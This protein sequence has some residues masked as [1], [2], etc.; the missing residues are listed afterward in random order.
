MFSILDEASGV[1]SVQPAGCHSSLHAIAPFVLMPLWDEY[2]LNKGRYVVAVSEFGAERTRAGS[3]LVASTAKGRQAYFHRVQNDQCPDQVA[4][5]H[6][7]KSGE[8]VRMHGPQ[9]VPERVQ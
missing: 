6:G 7:S 1:G 5:K 3:D 8:Q 2:R 9:H 4:C